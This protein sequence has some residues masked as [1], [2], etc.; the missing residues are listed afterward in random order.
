MSEDRNYSF[1][2]IPLKCTLEWIGNTSL[3]K[4][5]CNEKIVRFLSLVPQLVY[6]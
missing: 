4:K 6:H 2:Q 1:S 5:L 3:N